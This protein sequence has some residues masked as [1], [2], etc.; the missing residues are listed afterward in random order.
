MGLG[1]PKR[2]ISSLRAGPLV[3]CHGSHSYPGFHDPQRF[4]ES[5]GFHWSQ[6]LPDY[7]KMQPSPRLHKK[8]IFDLRI[9]LTI[10]FENLKCFTAP[11]LPI[12]LHKLYFL[13]K[14]IDSYY[15]QFN[16]W[17]EIQILLWKIR[18]IVVFDYHFFMLFYLLSIM[19][20]LIIMNS[21][22]SKEI[23]KRFPQHHQPWR[24]K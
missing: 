14:S 23:M 24:K 13:L 2:F 22:C 15:Q 9:Q 20:T 16:S 21:Y 19:A 6:S 10:I 12:L 18:C 8:S 17:R 3:P 1:W 11:S 5:H 7:V 4:D